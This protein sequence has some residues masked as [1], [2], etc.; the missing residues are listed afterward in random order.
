MSSF[1]SAEN[2]LGFISSIIGLLSLYKL[3]V[4]TEH[5]PRA[6]YARLEALLLNVDALYRLAIENDH[7][8]SRSWADR[9]AQ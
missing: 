3:F 9:L 2:I 5:L 7:P 1:A 8:H 4:Y 6:S